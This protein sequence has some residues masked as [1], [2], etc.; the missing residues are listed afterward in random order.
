MTGFTNEEPP[1]LSARGVLKSSKVDCRGE[2]VVVAPAPPTPPAPL[3]TTKKATARSTTTATAATATI[4][5]PIAFL[6]R[7]IDWEETPRKVI[8]LLINVFNR[9]QRCGYEK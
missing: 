4:T 5:V 6:L 2:G 3:A 9:R 1:D 7:I 8:I